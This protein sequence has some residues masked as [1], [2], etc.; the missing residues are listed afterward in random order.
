MWTT[1][2]PVVRDWVERNLGPAGRLEDV[3]TAAREVGRFMESLPDRLQHIDTAIN[4]LAALSDGG[5]RLDGETVE[6]LA[7][8]G[9]RN[10]Y[11]SRWAI[12]VGAVALV[13]IAV[14]AVF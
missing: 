10:V 6:Q 12:R 13:V 4:R 14:L 9:A 3:A 11:W 1:A 7:R 2:E 8:A 5:L